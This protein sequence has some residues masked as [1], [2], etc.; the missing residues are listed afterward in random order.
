[1]WHIALVS[2]FHSLSADHVLQFLKIIRSL[3]LTFRV[4]LFLSANSMSE[5]SVKLYNPLIKTLN[6]LR[7]RTNLSRTSVK[8]TSQSDSAPLPPTRQ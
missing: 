2:L 5:F 8:T 6:R 4:H 7:P 1:M 3:T